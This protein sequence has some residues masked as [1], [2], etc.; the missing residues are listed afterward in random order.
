MMKY[1]YVTV[2]LSCTGRQL[3]DLACD[4]DT[5]S[6]VIHHDCWGCKGEGRRQKWG[7]GGVLSY[8]CSAASTCSSY[9]RIMGKELKNQCPPALL[10]LFSFFLFLFVCFCLII[11]RALVPHFKPGS[12][13]SGSARRGDYGPAFPDELHVSPFPR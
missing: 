1:G 7:V 8:A 5:E 2:K 11:S 13:H 10:F 12:V 3:G 6:W 4:V 9:A